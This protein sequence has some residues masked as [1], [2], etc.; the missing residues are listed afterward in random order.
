MEPPRQATEAGRCLP[1]RLSPTARYWPRA[2]YWRRGHGG[3]C[4]R[5]AG[6]QSADGRG[7]GKANPRFGFYRDPDVAPLSTTGSKSEEMPPAFSIVAP[8]KPPIEQARRVSRWPKGPT[9][10]HSFSTK[11]LIVLCEVGVFGPPRRAAPNSSFGLNARCT[12][13]QITEIWGQSERPHK[14]LLTHATRA[15]L[16][17]SQRLIV[18]SCTV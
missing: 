18:T 13:F 15:T 6:D 16:R 7:L 10:N 17:S 2:R 11:H 5:R 12:G 4:R 8:E 3:S 9:W 1:G 14:A